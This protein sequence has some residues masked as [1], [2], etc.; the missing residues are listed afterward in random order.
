MSVAV[1]AAAKAEAK[2]E[3][4]TVSWQS[5]ARL[6]FCQLERVDRSLCGE[7]GLSVS[8]CRCLKPT[9]AAGEAPLLALLRRRV[10]SSFRPSCD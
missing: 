2:A 3:A 9:L 8:I 1:V 6:P 4:D 5:F 10:A 7:I